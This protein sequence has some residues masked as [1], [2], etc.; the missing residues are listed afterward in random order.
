MS[1][2]KETK[3][4]NAEFILLGYNNKEEFAIIEKEVNKYHKQGFTQSPTEIA[5]LLLELHTHKKYAVLLMK[6][7]K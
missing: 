6:E 1:I 3:R 4:I 2:T 7:L 5:E